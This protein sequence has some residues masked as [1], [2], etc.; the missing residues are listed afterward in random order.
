MDAKSIMQV[1]SDTAY[2]RTGGSPEELKTANY[3]LSRLEQW[4]VSGTL[5]AF[6]VDMADILEAEFTVDGKTIPCKGYKN[7]GSGEVEAELS[8]I[9]AI[10]TT[11]P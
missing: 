4:G 8:T 7:A 5:E 6:D 10:R 1:F 2:V 11:I 9:C 3:L